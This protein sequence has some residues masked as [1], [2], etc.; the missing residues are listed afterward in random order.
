MNGLARDTET[1]VT[2]GLAP[3]SECAGPLWE[4]EPLWLRG[5][6]RWIR[7]H[8][9]RFYNFRGLEAFKTAFAPTE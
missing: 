8:G 1:Y 3:L 9:R 4:T 6:M 2:M 5:L 7:A